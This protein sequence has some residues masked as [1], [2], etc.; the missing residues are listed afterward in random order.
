M[1]GNATVIDPASFCGGLP[2]WLQTAAAEY[3][4][5]HRLPV[6]GEIERLTDLCVD[7][8]GDDQ[9]TPSPLLGTS[10][11]AS[12]A[13]EAV[14]I[15]KIHGCKAVNALDSRTALDFADANLVVIYGANG[16]GKSG[17]ARLF[18]HATGQRGSVPLLPDVFA[19][20][21]SDDATGATFELRRG[22]DD[23]VV[24][25]EQSGESVEALRHAHVFDTL[26]AD[27]Y[28]RT[29]SES[30]YEPAEVGFF[31]GLIKICDLVAVQLERRRSLLVPLLPQVP[32]PLRS[33]PLA[34]RLSAL[35][36]AGM[37]GLLAT[38]VPAAANEPRRRQLETALRTI[39]PADRIRQID[40]ESGELLGSRRF[41]DDLQSG[42]SADVGVA[43]K[44]LRSEAASTRAAAAAAAPLV[45][46]S[47]AL[48]GLGD[49]TWRALWGAA[50]AYSS[51]AAFPGC[52]FPHTGVDSRCPLC[53]QTLDAPAAARLQSFE[54][55]VQ[56]TLEQSAKEAEAAVT[57]A[58]A[59][60]PELPS[61]PDWQL[62]FSRVPDVGTVAEV[63]YAAA[64]ERLRELGG[65][66]ASGEPGALDPGPLR[67]VLER[68]LTALADERGRL[69]P[70]CDGPGRARM[71]TELRDLQMLSWCME[72]RAALEAEV[73]RLR[74][75]D[76]LDRAKKLTVT[77]KLTARV[78]DLVE[79]EVT[80][81][82]QAR[83]AVELKA[84]G[85]DRLP[86]KPTRAK[87]AKGTVTHDL[88]L[89]KRS[90]NRTG[91]DE[92]ETLS[93]VRAS[94]VLSEGEGRIAALA[95]FLADVTSVD[96]RSPF[97]FDD[98][99]SSLDQDFEE[100]VVK[101]LF[102]LARTRQ[103]IVLTHRLSLRAL[104]EDAAKTD[105][106]LATAHEGR[107]A[108]VVHTVT[109][110]RLDRRVGVVARAHDVKIKGGGMEDLINRRLVGARRHSE[111]C[112]VDEYDSAMKEICSDLRIFTEKAI[113]EVLLNE[114]VLR[115]RR[116][117]I[118]KDKLAPLAK[119]VPED[120]A[121]LE[122]LM[123]RLS[124]FEHSQS[125]EAP[126]PPPELEEVERD[127]RRLRAWMEEFGKRKVPAAP[128]P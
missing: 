84:L 10:F 91:T 122:D 32:V 83:F 19:E 125:L 55:F 63:A 14:R 38:L 128:S 31:R 96:A 67:E 104:L 37:G 99:I 110:R 126:P 59:K 23:V 93:N 30:R 95:A 2:R 73:V 66:S 117:V 45:Q 71:E 64:S 97:L 90:A 51:Q 127:A 48:P 39:D 52:A 69:A 11:D 26:V 118:T 20:Q 9:A 16:A 58:V 113:E 15:R 109:L 68:Q 87:V 21:P 106:K 74:A 40:R 61:A 114:V 98:P 8:N 105:G 65:A 47:A 80:K 72:N 78:R 76:R 85:G 13:T 107:P 116:N 29:E 86:V 123:S 115:F 17:Y 124:V 33:T 79:G 92:D 36:A 49:E 112:E 89:V 103:V 120:C 44:A 54:A 6:G 42:L 53:H 5:E 27:R 111:R 57:R 121:L 7:D 60:L 4:R 81:A 46:D 24:A 35:D 75:L 108:V 77:T 62:R 56:G 22:E 18:K 41:L 50:R 43:M 28:L 34:S 88:S 25:W 70:L 82:Y 101:R 3:L 94:T 12:G 1:E 102:E 119:I 100:R